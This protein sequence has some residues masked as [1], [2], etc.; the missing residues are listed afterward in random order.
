MT[1]S[2]GWAVVRTV[3]P[4]GGHAPAVLQ[5]LARV[6]DRVDGAARFGALAAG[7]QR[8]DVDDPLALLAGDAGPVVGVGGVRQVLVLPELV[9]AR[10]EQVL[11]SQALALG[12]E[13]LL[14]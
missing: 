2:R 14:D 6:G 7:D 13:E 4:I 11:Q 9:H 12:G 10:V 1:A 3:S 8:A 5:V